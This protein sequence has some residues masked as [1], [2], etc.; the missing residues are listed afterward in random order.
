MKEKLIIF[1]Y[2]DKNGEKHTFKCW[3]SNFEKGRK[4][5]LA[6]DDIEHIKEVFKEIVK[7]RGLD[8]TKARLI[9][10]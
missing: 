1:E 4:E 2:E 9:A 10:K 6:K 7:G 5:G 8:E 3:S